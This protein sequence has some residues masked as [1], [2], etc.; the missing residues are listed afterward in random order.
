MEN[1]QKGRSNQPSLKMLLEV[2]GNP[3]CFLLLQALADKDEVTATDLQVRNDPN[4]QVLADIEPAQLTVMETEGYINRETN[5][6]VITQ[7]PNFA[8]VEP[9]LNNWEFVTNQL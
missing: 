2:I 1:N 7:G 9:Y 8:A 3:R 4:E 5:D 6:R